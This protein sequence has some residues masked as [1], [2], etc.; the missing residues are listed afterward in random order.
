MEFIGRQK[1]LST[2]KGLFNNR[3]AS[4]VVIKGRRRI[5]KSRLAQ[6]FGKSCT[7]YEFSGITPEPNTTAR[8]QRSVFA[9]RLEKYFDLPK[10]QADDWSDLFT[11]LAKNCQN[12]RVVILFDEISWMGTKD[13]TFLG[14]LKNAW[15]LEF[16]KNS[17]LVLI[18]CGSVS[19]WIEKNI[20]NST[21]FVG[22]PSLYLTLEEL[23]LSDC[24]HFWDKQGKGVSTYEK[25]KVL[26]VM[27]GVPR[28]LELIHPNETAED[29]I[30]RLCFS[31]HGPLFDEFNHIFTDIFSK[32]TVRY[33]DIISQLIY[34]SADQEQ[35]SKTLNLTRS[36]ELTSQLNE[37]VIAGFL[38]RDFTWHLKT[39]D[40]SKL[41]TYR[42]KDNYVRF[43]L[44][45]I[46][47][48]KEQ[49][50]RD[51]FA[52]KSL[53]ALPGWEAI[54]GLQFENLVINNY[55]SLVEIMEIPYSDIV[56]ANPF[57]QRKTSAMSGCQIDYLIQ[58]RFQN[59]YLCEI[60]FSQHP[61]GLEIIDQ[62]KEKIKRL[63]LPRHYSYRPV[64]IHVNGVRNEVIDSGFFSHI[65][66]FGEFLTTPNRPSS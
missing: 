63:V 61:I 57:F 6:E 48:Q 28:Y 47:S 1:E 51:L 46:A 27:G 42:L 7:Y 45:Y 15:D 25:L 24:N 9:R 62:M 10:L 17:Q 50:R 31:P 8:N 44:R 26:S 14:K 43:Y 21:G 65:I 11:L 18:L 3:A 37:L 64:L 53:S 13:P 49:I 38:S 55:H 20:I 4:L 30:R 41:S 32:K 52:M 5:G 39:G 23:Q 59:V 16:S 33:Q 60:K 58:T 35:I 2:L 34:S 40:I 29:N 12:G 19:S 56:F 36:G 66:D 54:M 22:R